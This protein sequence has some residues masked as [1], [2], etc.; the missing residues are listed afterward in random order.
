MK[1]EEI[2]KKKD[3]LVKVI[4]GPKDQRFPMIGKF[5]FL[6]D[7]DEL[8]SKG[9]VRFVNQ[10]KLEFFE[11]GKGGEALTK[12]YVFK[13]FSQ[14]IEVKDNIQRLNLMDVPSVTED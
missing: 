11:K 13:D 4:F 9:M 6:K 10:T 2:T 1:I 5:V 12:I 14:I 3:K 7:A 8:S